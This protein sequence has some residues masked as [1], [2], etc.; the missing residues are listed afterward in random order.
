MPIE[1]SGNVKSL[2]ITEMHSELQKWGEC[3]TE[4]LE[5]GAD[6]HEKCISRVSNLSC[7]QG[8]AHTFG[9]KSLDIELVLLTG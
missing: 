8:T 7:T 5:V 9:E 4:T 3:W 6:D 2:E 1:N